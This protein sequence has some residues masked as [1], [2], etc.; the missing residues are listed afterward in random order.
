ML[1]DM[2]WQVHLS[3]HFLVHPKNQ[4]YNQETLTQV[5][6]PQIHL[7]A[8]H[9]HIGQYHSRRKELQMKALV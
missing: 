1:F 7:E 6:K 2:I 8:S 4:N 5:H 9:E 3:T